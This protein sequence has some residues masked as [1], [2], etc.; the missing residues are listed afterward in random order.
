MTTMT[1]SGESIM[2]NTVESAFA[3][4]P[5]MS[6][7]NLAEKLSLNME[8]LSTTVRRWESEGRVRI[9][10]PRCAGSCSSCSSCSN[11]ESEAAQNEPVLLS[12]TSIVIYCKHICEED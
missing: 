8:E 4:R 3:S 11:E 2:L 9:V 10:N 6:A 12:P 5:M 7:G 1:T